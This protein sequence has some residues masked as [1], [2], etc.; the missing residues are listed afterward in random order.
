MPLANRKPK[1]GRRGSALLVCTLAATVLS[2]AAIAIIRSSKR[3]IARVDAVRTTAQGRCVADG[4]FQRSIAML[5]ID[6]NTT[7]SF[8]DAGNG[9]PDARVDLRQLSAN[10]TQIQVFLYAASTVPAKDVVVRTDL[11]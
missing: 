11:L 1:H 3:N 8:S 2:M 7:G 5:R 4:L 6:P 10:Q 9:M